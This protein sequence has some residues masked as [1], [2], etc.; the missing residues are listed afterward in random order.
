MNSI[1]LL[2]R[3]V[4]YF[5]MA[6]ALLLAFTLP[7]FVGAAQVTERSVALSSSSKSAKNV[8]YKVK[9][10]AAAA[11]TSFVLD[12]CSNSPA[13]GQICDAPV[14]FKSDT[15]ETDDSGYAI[16]AQT[17]TKLVITKSIA[18]NDV[19]D[20]ELTGIDNPTAAGPLYARIVTYSNNTSAQAYA[21]TVLGPD[22]VDQGGVAMSIT[23]TVGVSGAVLESMVFCVASKT[24]TANC[25]DAAANPPVLKLGE[26]VSEG[27]DTL[28]LNASTVSTGNIFTQISTNAVNGAVV[29][30]KSNT[31]CGGMNRVGL[32]TCDIAPALQTGVALGQAKFG[33]TATALADTGTSPIGNLRI[34]PGSGY[35]DS[36][37][38]LNFAQ[39]NQTG[40]TSTFGDPFL[41]TENAPVNGKNMQ[42]TFGASVNQNT[43]AGLYST[44]LRLIAT[45]KF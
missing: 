26:P 45:G 24:I 36:A 18:A 19:I 7:T 14:G 23:E 6:M 3:R 32:T 29:S 34:F 37:Y 10:T 17:A 39:D 30:L 31:P 9:F 41:D 4:G 11:A 33:V 21:S 42:L 20:V 13:I 8:T 40:V 25:G 43:P 38:A 12:F 44:D 16:L 27:S 1:K 5:A 28:A 2:D 35:S 15:A 22:V